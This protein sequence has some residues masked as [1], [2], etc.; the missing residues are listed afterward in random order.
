MPTS[1]QTNFVADQDTYCPT[2]ML[3]LTSA[4]SDSDKLTIKSTINAMT[5]QGGT[6]QTVG[7]QWGWLSLLQQAPLN[8]PSED[9]NN[10][11]Q[12]VII[13][14]T[15]GQNTVNRWSGTGTMSTPAAERAKIDDRMKLLCEAI[16]AKKTT[17]YTVQLDDGTGVSP[18]LP[19]CASG[20]SNFFM[21]T[22]PSEIDGAFAR[23]GT[24]ISKLRV[25]Q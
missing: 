1:L 19:A 23:I 4:F 7:L 24:S 10:V 20:P 15:D 18:V 5:A 25:S 13:L 17:I 2:K 6:N 11:Y 21:L 12:H 14:F 9:P 22:D 8:A 3:P 16:K